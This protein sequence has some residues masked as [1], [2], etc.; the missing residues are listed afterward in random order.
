MDA[1]TSQGHSDKRSPIE[2]FENVPLYH[3]GESRERL[4]TRRHDERGT[5]DTCDVD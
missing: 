1:T 5:P 4:D 2:M 3:E